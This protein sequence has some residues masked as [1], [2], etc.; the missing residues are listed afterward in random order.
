MYD[1]RLPVSMELSSNNIATNSL[2]NNSS[3]SNHQMMGNIRSL[4]TKLL[5]S[6]LQHQQQSTTATGNGTFS[7]NEFDIVDSNSLNEDQTSSTINTGPNS[8][9]TSKK[10]CD[11]IRTDVLSKSKNLDELSAC[12]GFLTFLLNTPKCR[13]AVLDSFRQ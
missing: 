4:S 8:N 10:T 7:L 1:I 9:Q 2:S 3:L 5:L 13:Y 6:T 12:V 11:L